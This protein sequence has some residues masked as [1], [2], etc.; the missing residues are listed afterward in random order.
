MYH[1]IEN[2]LHYICIAIQ[3]ENGSTYDSCVPHC[4]QKSCDDYISQTTEVCDDKLCIEGNFDLYSNI[5][6]RIDFLINIV[7]FVKF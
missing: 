7:Y 2:K 1:F 6:D 3:C 4:S 5:F